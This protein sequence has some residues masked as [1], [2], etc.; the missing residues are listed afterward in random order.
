MCKI[1][2]FL[3]TCILTLAK[4]KYSYNIET[5]AP[6][7]SVFIGGSRGGLRLLHPP[8]LWSDNFS[9]KGHFWPLLG[10][11]PPFQTEW[12]TK[13]VMRGCTPPFQKFLDPPWYSSSICKVFFQRVHL[14]FN[15][16]R[17]LVNVFITCFRH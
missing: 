9:K 4:V 1:K 12:L 11:Q 14:Y 8:P 5:M 2:S 15:N 17:H 16:A 7:V 6:R 3:Q 13:L 10:L